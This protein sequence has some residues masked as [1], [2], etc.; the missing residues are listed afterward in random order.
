MKVM[1]GTTPTFTLTLPEDIDLDKATTV[2]VTLS[3][4]SSGREIFTKKT[5]ELVIDKNV[6]YVF[7]TQEETLSFPSS[8]QLQ[9]NWVY[10]DAG[11]NKRASSE[12]V[13]IEFANNL[14][15]KVVE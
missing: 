4:M 10:D 15:N 7:L 11:V 13:N 14:L 8:A 5:E 9:V 12:I 2:Y 6:I 1:K 3:Y